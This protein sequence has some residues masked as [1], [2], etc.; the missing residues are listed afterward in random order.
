VVEHLP[1]ICEALRSNPSTTKVNK[2]KKGR[3]GRKERREG[4]GKEARKEG[5]KEGKEEGKKGRRK[6]RRKTGGK[7]ILAPWKH[8]EIP[9]SFSTMATI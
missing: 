9:H 4:G 3:G 1:R 8:P 7:N 5:R 2:K 6:E